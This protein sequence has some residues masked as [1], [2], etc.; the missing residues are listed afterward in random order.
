MNLTE[1]KFSPLQ[2]N[3]QAIIFDRSGK[4]SDSDDTLFKLHGKQANIF[5]DTLFAGMDELVQNL[6]VDEQ[7]TFDC[8]NTELYG[9]SSFYDLVVVK[10]SEDEQAQYALLVYD[11]GKQYNK[12]LELQQERNLAE[13]KLRKV[14]REKSHLQKEKDAIKKL[15]KEMSEVGNSQYILIKADNL[16]IN[17]EFKD[18]FYFEAF[19]DYVKVHTAEKLY[20]TYNRLSVIEENL[21]KGQ[22]VRIHRSFIVRKDKIKNIEQYSLQIQD[23]ILPIGK[24]QKASVLENL[25]Q[26]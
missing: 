19:G 1:L 11:F 9:R 4:V 25:R 20:V 13:I 12:I 22:F 23:K 24:S 3:T 21:P 17:V 16:L 8:V 2:T 18:I 15:Y 14:E 6:N 7:I 10:I 26:L 5:D